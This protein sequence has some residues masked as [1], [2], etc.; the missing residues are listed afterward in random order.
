MWVAASDRHTPLSWGTFLPGGAATRH[1]QNNTELQPSRWRL[2]M[3]RLRSLW[4]FVFPAFPH[5]L[6]KMSH[7]PQKKGSDFLVYLKGVSY[8]FPALF[9]AFHLLTWQL[10]LVW[11]PLPHCKKKYYFSQFNSKTLRLNLKHFQLLSKDFKNILSLLNTVF[12]A[13]LWLK[14]TKEPTTK[15]NSPYL[16]NRVHWT[17][18]SSLNTRHL[19]NEV[20]PDWGSGCHL[21]HLVL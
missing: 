18:K 16:K 3:L 2:A 8:L 17:A 20:L 21:P 5:N 4:T 6:L 19:L 13:A 10:S 14:G 9:H 11:T 15:N 7:F 1:E 12:F